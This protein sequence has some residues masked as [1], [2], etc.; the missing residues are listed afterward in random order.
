[1]LHKC[2]NMRSYSGFYWYIRTLPR[3]LCARVNRAYTGILVKPL[4]AVLQ[5][6]NIGESD[7]VISELIIQ[8]TPH[9]HKRIKTIKGVK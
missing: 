8:V 6:I 4:A 5:H 9:V 7:D 2:C 1:M 3:A